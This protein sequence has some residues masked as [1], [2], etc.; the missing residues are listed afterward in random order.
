[1]DF[2]TFPVIELQERNGLENSNSWLNHLKISLTLNMVLL[3]RKLRR[4]TK[5]LLM[6]LKIK[7]YLSVAMVTFPRDTSLLQF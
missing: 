7:L 6:L 3:L 5:N 4:H 2:L 1:M